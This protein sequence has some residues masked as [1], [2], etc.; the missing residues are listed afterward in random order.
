MCCLVPSST[1]NKGME[2]TR[3]HARLM[4]LFGVHPCGY[5][6]LEGGRDVYLFHN[7]NL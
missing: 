6:P 5:L 7:R 4:P 2:A 1:P 3:Y